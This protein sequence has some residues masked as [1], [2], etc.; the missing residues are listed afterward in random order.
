MLL[1]Q[2]H[3]DSAHATEAIPLD[4]F[5]ALLQLI[6]PSE[7]EATDKDG[8]SALRKAISLYGKDFIAYDSLYSLIERL[9]DHYPEAIYMK[10]KPSA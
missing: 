9:V 6:D 3:L 10:V 5:R 4:G 7:Q 2:V 1:D 8:Y